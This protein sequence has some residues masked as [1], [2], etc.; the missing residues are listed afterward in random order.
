[1]AAAGCVR[2]PSR[3]RPAMKAS[4]K[5]W[6]SDARG[7][8]RGPS[9]ALMVASLLAA[10]GLSAGGYVFFEG[11]PS[12]KLPK[13]VADS[14]SVVSGEA[15]DGAAAPAFA[16]MAL[17]PKPADPAPAGPD[18]SGVYSTAVAKVKAHQAGGL[19][20]I[21]K[22]ADG[23]YAPAEF[24]LATLYQ[25]RRGRSRQ[26]PD[27][28]ATLAGE[29]GRGRR[30]HRHAQSGARRARGRS[31]VRATPRRRPSGSAGPPSSACWTASSTSRPST[32]TAT[33]SAR[34]R[35]RPTSGT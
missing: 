30:P 20:E 28:V 24:Y 21:E 26:G 12:G 13:R 9:G 11:K 22:L 25:R 27:A 3:P 32:S 17:S 29:G 35:P 15:S 33:A 8:V 2:R 4:C 6:R 19:A 7:A 5:G 10:I 31:A 1:M 18:L 23:G 34:T 16:A 14:L